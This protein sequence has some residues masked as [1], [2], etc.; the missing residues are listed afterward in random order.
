MLKL[1]AV[2]ELFGTTR[3]LT[4]S[5][6]KY[7]SPLPGA[8]TAWLVIQMYL[9]VPLAAGPLLGCLHLRASDTLSSRRFRLIISNLYKDPS[10]FCSIPPHHNMS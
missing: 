8:E 6:L 3:V 9:I 10:L 7:T 1:A 2:A 4:I 5:F